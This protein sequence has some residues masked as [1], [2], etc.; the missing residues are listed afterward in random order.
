[1]KY[2][3]LLLDIDNTLYHY[4]TVHNAA[5]NEIYIFFEKTFQIKQK[6]FEELY[7][8]A[9]NNNHQILE[10]TASAHNRL[11]YFQ[12]IFEQ[13]NISPLP[14]SYYCNELYWNTFLNHIQLYDGVIDVLKR[15][16][17]KICLVTDLT[18]DI[19]HKKILHLKLDAYIN[20]IVTSEEAGHEKPHPFIFNLALQ[21]LDLYVDNVCM[22]GDNFK[23][24]I[25]GAYNLGIKSIWLNDTKQIK[26]HDHNMITEVTHFKAI[27]EHI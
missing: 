6:E 2:K 26:N 23:K 3:A 4:D 17:N 8:Y 13:L 27:L 24:D 18:A 10:N 9:K 16:H 1:M 14:Y 15:Y 12:K 25:F 11:L 21:K 7:Q 5:M 20:Q 22:I 19:Q